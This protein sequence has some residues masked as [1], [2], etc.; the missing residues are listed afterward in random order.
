MK[1]PSIKSSQEK[2]IKFASSDQ[3]SYKL[4]EAQLIEKLKKYEGIDLE[5]MN[6]DIQR[7]REE[8]TRLNVSLSKLMEDK[9]IASLKIKERETELRKYVANMSSKLKEGDPEMT[10]E[11]IKAINSNIL[12]NIEMIRDVTRA[13]IKE[14][15]NEIDRRLKIRKLDHDKNFKDFL[16]K[17]TKEQEKS[18]EASVAATYEMNKIQDNYENILRRTNEKKAENNAIKENLK[19][20]LNKNDEMKEKLLNLRMVI[21]NMKLEMEL[22]KIKVE[23]IDEQTKIKSK[24]QKE[25]EEKVSWS[26]EDIVNEM[27]RDD[28]RLVY[29]RSANTILTYQTM[30]FKNKCKLTSFVKR[31]D[32]EKIGNSPVL[33]VVVELLAKVKE[34]TQ[35]LF[36]SGDTRVTLTKEDRLVLVKMITESQEV[37]DVLMKG[38]YPQVMMKELRR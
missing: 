2:K 26:M 20:I 31:I 17:K 14:N 9:E 32:Q 18:Q 36:A 37:I 33:Q 34:N 27:E 1:L 6:S 13:K 28:F 24:E 16:N 10:K 29:G 30:L 3:N 15:K 35:E 25:P 11:S 4:T 38:D 5:K 19:V 12:E 7:K 22:A 21:N 23:P 8:L